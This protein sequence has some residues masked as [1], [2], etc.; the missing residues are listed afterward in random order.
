MVRVEYG[1]F[2]PKR[3]SVRRKALGL[4][5]L[6]GLTACMALAVNIIAP[7]SSIQEEELA[8]V[9]ATRPGYELT[10]SDVDA[11]VKEDLEKMRARHTTTQLARAEPHGKKAQ[12]RGGKHSK[13]VKLTVA[14]AKPSTTTVAA[15]T[16]MTAVKAEAHTMR[17]AS[18]TTLAS[19]ELDQGFKSAK[20]QRAAAKGSKTAKLELELSS[21]KAKVASLKKKEAKDSESNKD[22]LKKL[23]QLK[24]E[25]Q[26]LKKLHKSQPTAKAAKPVKTQQAAATPQHAFG[27]AMRNGHD[28]DHDADEDAIFGPP[29]AISSEELDD[30]DEKP[31]WHQ[32]LAQKSVH[33]DQSDEVDSAKL[34]DYNKVNIKK[35]LAD[36]PELPG[37]AKRPHKSSL[38][39]SESNEKGLISE[40]SDAHDLR[41]SMH[42]HKLSP[43]AKMLQSTLSE[44]K[45]DDES[46]AG[47]A[48]DIDAIYPAAKKEKLSGV[49]KSQ[50]LIKDDSGLA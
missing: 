7:S 22:T 24:T 49:V 41:M 2:V 29:S 48:A 36:L 8:E 11:I 10:R 44:L 20:L 28:Y 27:K 34:H 19:S 3:T 5:V 18:K 4:G 17:K 46:V 25:V 15:K 45:S 9:S 6:V 26:S 23:A 13:P 31:S 35:T 37:G 1:T 12:A 43:V 42:D 16:S 39:L 32:A 50:L 14:A 40:L 38:T 47:H 21:E 30:E 33:T